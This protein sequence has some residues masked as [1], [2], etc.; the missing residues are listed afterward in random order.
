VRA[1]NCAIKW[2]L[3][4]EK[5]FDVD[6]TIDRHL[7]EGYLDGELGFE[8]T[9]EV[10]AHLASCRVC[11]SEVQSWKDVRGAL[12]RSDLYHRAPANFKEQIRRVV[13]RENRGERLPWFH[14]WI[15]AGGGAAFATA[16]LLVTF[17]ISR[18]GAS[19]AQQEVVT[20]HVRSLMANHLMDVISTD[21]HTV[22][23]WF[24]GKLD[25]APPVRDLATEGFPLAGGRLD[26]LEN[27][28][29]AVLIYHRGLHV[30]NLYVW[31]AADNG[32]SPVREQTIQGYNVVSWKKNAFECRA[33]SD[34]NTDELRD[35]VRLIRP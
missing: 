20:S 25:F 32:I 12:Q 24:D 29:V 17:M 10:E 3:P 31:P 30:I 21:Q 34:L 8:R 19:S 2:V 15:W 28:T 22:K 23:P 5:E 35:F 13:P 33:V 16:A 6:C 9:L 14:R 27:R 1:S 4:Q 11:D 18:P 7:L 26:Y